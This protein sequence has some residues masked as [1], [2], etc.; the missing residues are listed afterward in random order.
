MYVENDQCIFFGEQSAG[1]TVE[2]ENLGFMEVRVRCRVCARGWEAV[3]YIC[4]YIQIHVF[5]YSTY[6]R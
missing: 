2:P 1:W 5:T 4:M 6:L 3:K